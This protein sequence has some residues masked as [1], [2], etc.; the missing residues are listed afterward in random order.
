MVDTMKQTCTV[1]RRVESGEGRGQS[2]GEA[3]GVFWEV[4]VIAGALSAAGA[5]DEVDWWLSWAME[6]S[7]T[8]FLALFA[9][10]RILLFLFCCLG[11]LEGGLVTLRKKLRS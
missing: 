11:A 7:S 8:R 5:G 6:A 9:A 4:V 10:R 3:A 1:S 2:V